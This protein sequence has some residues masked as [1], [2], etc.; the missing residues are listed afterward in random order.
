MMSAD[1]LASCLHRLVNHMRGL[2]E[3]TGAEQRG[4]S[5]EGSI[6]MKGNFHV[7]FLVQFQ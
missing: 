6:R 1:G 5:V 4:R 7:R 3:K 2:Q